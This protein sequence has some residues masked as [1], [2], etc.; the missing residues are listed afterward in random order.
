[1]VGRSTA[2]LIP[3]LLALIAGT[4]LVCVRAQAQAELTLEQLN[5]RRPPDYTPIYNGQNVTVRGVVSAPAFRFPGYSLL[6]IQQ[7]GYGGIVEAPENNADLAGCRPGDEIEV[8]GTVSFRSGMVTVVSSQTRLLGRKPAPVPEN[9]TPEELMGFRHL[10]ELVHT[11]GRVVEVGDTT[12][13]AYL[14]VASRSGNYKIFLPHGS[15]LASPSLAGFGV[16]DGIQVT[17]VGF[18]YCPVPPY[19]RWFELLVGNASAMVRTER[20]GILPPMAVAGGLVCILIFGLLLWTRDRRLRGQRERLRKTYQLGE[21][22]LSA[23]SLETILAQ[24]SEALPR[25]LG[26]TGVHLYVYNRGTKALDAVE[27]ADQPAASISLSSPPGG[28]QAGAVACFHYRT[29]LVIPDV[30]RSPFPIASNGPQRTPKSLLFVPMLSQGDVVGVLE[31]DQG[32]RARDFTTDEQALAQHLGNQIGVAVRLLD[33]RSVQEQLFRTEKLAAVGRLISGVVN[34][35]QTPLASIS[36]L[37]GRAL[38]RSAGREVSAIAAEAQKASAIVARLVSFAASEQVEARPV[39]VTTLLRN[40]IEFRERDWKA[41]GIR[42]HD[43]TLHEPVYVLGSHGQLEQ[44]FLTLFVHAEQ[45]LAEAAQKMISIRSS[46]LAKRLL[47]EISFTAPP[48]ARTPHETA[49]VLGVTRSVITGHGG[50]VRLIE[51]NTAEPRFEVELPVTVRERVSTVESNG[52]ARDFARRMTALIIEADEAAQRQL[53]VLLS[54][55]GYRV[56]PVDDADKGLEL[57]QRMRFDAAFCSVHA[58]G[59]NWVELSERMQSRVG[60]F[61]LLSDRY[62]PELSA[63]F[64]GEARFVVPKPV[65]ETD[66]DRVLRSIDA[67]LAGRSPVA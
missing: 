67:L 35:L 66:L 41:S 20:P 13:G 34:E 51:K 58:P 53:L 6:A 11:G 43:L 3:L 17:G 56:V 46:V 18:Q 28:T 1:M 42:V 5:S 15:H 27:A 64:E 2:R 30:D 29:L 60:G 26:V 4:A 45:A 50:E 36:E 24:V 54:A 19:N 62:D 52:A 9:L 31:L 14:L 32:D 57:A 63:D 12:G 22:I 65:Q 25:I 61:I 38:Q 16:G 44:A 8:E 59:L 21:E 48:D 10:G 47:V 40:L 39:C 37:A 7:G 23:A 33:Q 49:A 55:R